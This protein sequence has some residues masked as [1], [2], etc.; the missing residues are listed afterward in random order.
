MSR[1]F[2]RKGFERTEGTSWDRAGCK[3]DRHY[4]ERDF[5]RVELETGYSIQWNYR[6]PT[7]QERNSR[8]WWIHGDSKS[9]TF[10][11]GRMYRGP[12]ERQF[13]AANRRELVKYLKNPDYEPMVW[14]KPTDCWWD[15][16]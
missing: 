1:T 13:R 15:W 4:V 11:Y 3:I 10:K 14:D 12:K 2:R 8:Y 6:A 7:E 9:N 16:R 5:T